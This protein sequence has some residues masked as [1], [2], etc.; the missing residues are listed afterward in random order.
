MG[1]AMHR[2]HDLIEERTGKQLPA[3]VEAVFHARVFA[4]FERSSRCP[5]SPTC[6]RSWRQTVDPGEFIGES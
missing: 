2:V 1:S 6:W 4:A 5:V 3:A